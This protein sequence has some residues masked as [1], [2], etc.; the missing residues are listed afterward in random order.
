MPGFNLPQNTQYKSEDEQVYGKLADFS[1]NFSK[2]LKEQYPNLT[3]RQTNVIPDISSRPVSTPQNIPNSIEPS[4]LKEYPQTTP[5]GGNTK[6]EIYHPGID[7]AT[8]EYTPISSL[9]SGIVS[10]IVSGQKPG[11]SK[12]F[13]NYVV[14][15][16]PIT[17]N[18]FRYSHLNNSWMKVGQE[19]E[20][21]D[22]LGLSGRT[23]SVYSTSGGSGAHLDLRIWNAAKKFLNP[24]E[25]L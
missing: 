16:D 17:G 4:E 14:I 15:T 25:F 18:N 5:F 22:V 8:P 3:N 1:S 19:I 13:G 23:G 20:R 12:G 7:I 6:F 9:S 24:S 11:Q 10:N 21:G 2:S